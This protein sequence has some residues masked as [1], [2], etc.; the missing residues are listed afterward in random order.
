MYPRA[1]VDRALRLHAR[2]LDDADVARA[3][4]VSVQAVRH[5]HTGRRRSPAA[6]RDRTAYCPRCGSG[7][8]DTA[9]YAHLLGLYLGDGHIAASRR[10]VY[11]LA[12]FC[13]DRYPGLIEECARTMTAVLPCSAH[14]VRRTGCTAVR[15]ASKHWPCLFPQHGPGPKHTRP[16]RLDPWQREAVDAHP[17][18]FARGLLHSDGCRVV[19]RVRRRVGGA[20]RYYAYPRYFF[21][22]ASPDIAG[23]LCA[24]LDRLGVAWTRR[25]Q[26]RRHDRWA[27]AHIVSVARRDDVARLDL[28][29]G[30]KR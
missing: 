23:L 10:G 5:W 21:A 16:I 20:W 12:V 30:P 1:T 11:Y 26:Q 4:G 17:G 15:S 18:A 13:D 22:S 29:V 27:D 3:C 2:G 8:L 28:H 9:A 19:N 25:V 14:R 24:A 7:T 6:G